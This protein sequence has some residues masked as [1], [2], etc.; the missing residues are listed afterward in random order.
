MP[1][2]FIKDQVACVKGILDGSLEHKEYK[3]FAGISIFSV[4]GKAS[5]AFKP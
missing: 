4:F 3:S 5:V 2:E 1:A